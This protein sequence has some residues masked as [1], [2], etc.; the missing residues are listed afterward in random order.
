[1][2]YDESIGH[3]R[4]KSQISESEIQLLVNEYIDKASDKIADKCVD[5]IKNAQH[6]CEAFRI[7]RDKENVVRFYNTEKKIDD[8]IVVHKKKEEEDERLYNKRHKNTLLF[9]ALINSPTIYYIITKF[10]SFL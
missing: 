3:E 8:H 7:F 2:M 10:V 4:R 6:D 5:R 1:M 9:V